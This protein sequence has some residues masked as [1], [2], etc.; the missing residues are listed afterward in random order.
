MK[1]KLLK[2]KLF[3]FVTVGAVAAL[4]AGTASAA[5]STKEGGANEQNGAAG[6]PNSAWS[7]AQTQEFFRASDLT[8]KNVQDSAN[9][10][11]GEIKNI[12]FN[13][14]GNVFALVDVGRNRLAVVPWQAFS[15]P[16]AKGK[17]N[18]LVNMTAKEVEAGPVVTETQWGALNNPTFVEG[19]YSYYHVKP[20]MEQGG[21]T[22]PGGTE[23]GKESSHEK[24]DK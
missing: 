8:G 15:P 16:S 23:Q 1:A 19:V 2:H 3:T 18:L 20:A 21:A 9:Q 24:P 5:Q 7:K 10:K 6:Q 14:G 12:V 22:S 13:Q 17:Q 4:G 11:I